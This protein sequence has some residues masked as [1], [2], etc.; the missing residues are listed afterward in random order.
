MS[1]CY[2]G[3]TGAGEPHKVFNYFGP[4][5]GVPSFVMGFPL[6]LSWRDSS[7]GPTGI[8]NTE[9]LAE[10]VNWQIY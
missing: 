7:T 1:S 6:S 10:A 3:S 5:N 9:A 4:H 2:T 8:E